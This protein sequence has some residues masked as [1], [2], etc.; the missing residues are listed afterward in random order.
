LYAD[1]NVIIL[2]P[3]IQESEWSYFHSSYDKQL[4]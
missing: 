2:T 1:K 4:N 3:Y